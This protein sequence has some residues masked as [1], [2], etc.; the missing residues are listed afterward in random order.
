MEPSRDEFPESDL[1]EARVHELFDA[2]DRSIWA[3]LQF[4]DQLAG[5]DSPL[6]QALVE[7]PGGRQVFLT[8]TAE[9]N[10]RRFECAQL[11]ENWS[12]ASFVLFTPTEA[13]EAAACLFASEFKR[14]AGED[15]QIFPLVQANYGPPH[16]MSLSLGT[17]GQQRLWR[18]PQTCLMIRFE[19][20]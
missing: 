4:Q 18:N 8:V 14:V 1:A 19:P 10:L 2:M 5:G 7:L 13:L 9:G 20:R 3:R 17:L 6:R 12:P 16:S 11:P 15:L